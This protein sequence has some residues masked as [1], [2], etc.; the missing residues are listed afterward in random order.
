MA[1]VLFN[2]QPMPETYQFTA[3]SGVSP[4]EEV[5]I[6]NVAE[7]FSTSGFTNFVLAPLVLPITSVTIT[8][9]DAD[10][11]GFD[12]LVDTIT[13]TPGTTNTVPE[14]STALIFLSGVIGLWVVRRQMV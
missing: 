3:F 1:G 14:P 13:V 8:A 5:T 4:V 6:S 2:G 11:N 7:S 12:F 9:P 10:I